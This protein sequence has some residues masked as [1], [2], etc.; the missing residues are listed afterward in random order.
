MKLIFIYFLLA[1]ALLIHVYMV[2]S[3]TSEVAKTFTQT[4]KLTQ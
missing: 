2:S 3:C 1:L 4:P